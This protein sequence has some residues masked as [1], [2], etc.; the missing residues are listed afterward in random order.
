VA[1][2]IAQSTGPVLLLS[3][4][5]RAFRSDEVA[6][7]GPEAPEAVELLTRWSPIYRECVGRE[8]KPNLQRH[9]AHANLTLLFASHALA[10]DAF[11]SSRRGAIAHQ[12]GCVSRRCLS[13]CCP[14]LH[15]LDRHC[16]LT[17][18]HIEQHAHARA[19]VPFYEGGH[20]VAVHRHG[21]AGLKLRWEAGSGGGSSGAC[22]TAAAA[23]IRRRGSAARRGS[24]I[25]AR[26]SST[27][28]ASRSAGVNASP[29]RP[30]T[31]STPAVRQTLPRS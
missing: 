17:A 12:C 1:R 10:R 13:P 2:S 4:R 5:A 31:R 16:T 29:I 9:R 8:R 14:H 27:T 21:L 25:L 30:T 15:P 11:S 23:S 24:S 28:A 22:H 18:E 20:V 19:R 7:E 6:I 26:S 3:A